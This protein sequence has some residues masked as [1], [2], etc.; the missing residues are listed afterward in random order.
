MA[1]KHRISQNKAIEDLQNLV[2][3][4]QKRWGD[5]V[6]VGF[7]SANDAGAA[8]GA[9]NWVGIQTPGGFDGA[10]YSDDIRGRSEGPSRLASTP[11]SP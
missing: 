9:R 1:Q 5:R 6:R 2:F 8:L 10:M 3:G 4:V 11:A 7:G